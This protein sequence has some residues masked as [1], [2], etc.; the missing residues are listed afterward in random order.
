MRTLRFPIVVALLALVVGCASPNPAPEPAPVA[1]EPQVAVTV[2]LEPAT[3]GAI[4]NLH[5]QGGVFLASQPSAEDF[6][7][8]QQAGMRTVLD[9]R[10]PGEVTDFDEPTVVREL[11]LA[12]HNIGFKAPEE[13]TDAV[14]DGALAVLRDSQARPVLMHCSSANRVGAIWI[15]YRVLD[16]GLSWE[17]AL[18]EARTVG[19]RTDAFEARARAYVDAQRGL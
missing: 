14:F 17:A 10:K 6:R 4:E 12:Y 9:L 8:A 7:A 15:A 11:G 13:L 3:L 2:A 16:D 19:L 5:T 1:A 18:E